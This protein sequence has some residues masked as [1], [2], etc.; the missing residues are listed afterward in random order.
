MGGFGNGGKGA[1]SGVWHVLHANAAVGP[2]L[3]QVFAAKPNP[4]FEPSLFLFRHFRSKT[5]LGFFLTR[6]RLFSCFDLREGSESESWV[7]QSEVVSIIKSM[8]VVNYETSDV[9]FTPKPVA[10]GGVH[11]SA[12]LVS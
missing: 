11:C 8:T 2:S 4:F 5:R 3:S 1:N 7:Q 12:H 10:A 6:C 9:L